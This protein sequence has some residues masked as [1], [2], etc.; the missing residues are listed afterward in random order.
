VPNKDATNVLKEIRVRIDEANREYDDM[1]VVAQM[2]RG[3]EV[4]LA[5]VEDI[6]GLVNANLAPTE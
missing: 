4:W 5:C 6:Q 3:E 2:R 1:N